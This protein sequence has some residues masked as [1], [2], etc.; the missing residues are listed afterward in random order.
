MAGLV[1]LVDFDCCAGAG[2]ACEGTAKRAFGLCAVWQPKLPNRIADAAI[3]IRKCLIFICINH[4]P[5]C[6]RLGEIAN[7]TILPLDGST[8]KEVCSSYLRNRPKVQGRLR[9]TQKYPS[10]FLFT[11]RGT[12]ASKNGKAIRQEK[13][14]GRSSPK[15]MRTPE[16]YL[17]RF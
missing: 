4:L 14:H 8:P 15:S 10:P 6:R 3:S 13:S 17:P 12:F 2:G 11:L 9:R 7:P 1:D 16:M 5:P